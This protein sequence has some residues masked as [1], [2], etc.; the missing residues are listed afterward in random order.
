MAAD[1][2]SSDEFSQGPPS[3]LTRRPQSCAKCR[4]EG[5]PPILRADCRVHK[6]QLKKEHMNHTLAG[7]GGAGRR[8]GLRFLENTTY[9]T[10]MAPANSASSSTQ[11][12][13]HPLLSTQTG[14]PST[15]R[16]S[17]SFYLHDPR[18]M[19]MESLE[20]TPMGA[21]SAEG[22]NVDDGLVRRAYTEQNDLSLGSD[23]HS[24]QRDDLEM[25][26]GGMMD[27]SGDEKGPG[28]KRLSLTQ[29]RAKAWSTPLAAEESRA[30]MFSSRWSRV[31]NSA[32]ALGQSTGAYVAL[33]AWRDDRV[34]SNTPTAT[35]K[36]FLPKSHFSQSLQSL[37]DGTSA[38]I[39]DHFVNLVRETHPRF[40]EAQLES[41]RREAEEKVFQM[42]E[43]ARMEREEQDRKVKELERRLEEYQ[44]AGTVVASSAATGSSRQAAASDTVTATGIVDDKETVLISDDS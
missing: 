30:K 5:R 1:R 34:Q 11:S 27:G 37:P 38:R 33:L 36:T 21:E 31:E 32:I 4:Q 18:N 44:K 41:V 12:V 2:Q 14:G 26:D 42:E 22:A 16:S 10:L 3:N 28:G 35:H 19:P 23:G 7:P 6:R 15:D 8:P 43:R 39:Y 24:T 29:A 40:I 13:I 17:S 20:R 9:T 25:D